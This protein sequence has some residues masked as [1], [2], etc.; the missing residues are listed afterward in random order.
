MEVKKDGGGPWSSSGA[1]SAPSHHA[2]YRSTLIAFFFFFLVIGVFVGLLL[3]YLVQEQHYFM[4]TVELRG[5][6]YDP[7]LQD[8]N[9][10]YSIVLSSVLKSKIKNALTASSISQH[11]VD[12]S[13]V[14]YGNINGDVMATFRLV[15]RVSKVQQYSDNFVQ[16]LLRTGLSSA[17]HGKPLEVPD[18]GEINTIVLLGASGKSF[19][20]I[21]DEMIAK[22]P[23]NTFT[24][25]NGECV[26]KLNPEC[27]F[28]TDCADGSDEARC[29]E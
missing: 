4:E 24:C 20:A 1:S 13:I 18:F 17:M 19:Y 12:C 21:G 16:D 8:E 26:T 9:S 25:D 23:D 14:A 29:G 15:F 28:I 6:K 27:D 11:Y 22:C 10:G 5:L 7:V 3:A 2:C